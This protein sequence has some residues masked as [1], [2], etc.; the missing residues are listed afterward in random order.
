MH[1][2]L[3]FRIPALFCA[4][5]VIACELIAHPF[6]NM[7]VDDDGPYILMVQ[8]LVTTGHVAYNGWAAPMLTWQLYLAAAFVKLFGFSF[9]TVRGSTILV[10]A[11][12]AFFLQR[13]LVRS[14]INE[15][16][17]TI[18]TLA[19]V[20]SPLYLMLS[21]TFM[22]D[23]H[24]LFAVILCLYACLRALQSATPR[25]AIAWLCFAV[26]SNAVV[27]T[28][29]QI[30]WLGILVMVPS[31]LYL[32]RANRR[33]FL[34]GAA[35]TLA[36]V[37]FIFA[38]LHWLKHQP[39]NIP[40]H[41]LPKSLHLAHTLA[42]FIHTF[43]DIP[44]F[45]LPIFA[46]FLPQLRKSR[47]RV[48]AILSAIAI[49]YILLAIVRSH[50]HPNALLEPIEAD[51]VSPTGLFP[52]YLQGAPPVFLHPPVRLLLTIA[53][54]GGLIGLFASFTLPHK[55]PSPTPRLSSH[56]LNILLLPF[57]AANILLL[58]PRA[59]EWLTDRYLLILLA[60][61]LIFLTRFYQDQVRPR[62]P[63]TSAILVAIMATYAIAVTHNLFAL[64][65]ARVALAAE[66]RAAGIPD[67]A[68]DNGW[69]YN[70]GTELQFAPSLNFP[71]IV[72]PANFYTP[73]PPPP[74][75]TC[76]TYY[77]D[78]TPHVHPRIGVSFD[79]NACA[80]P[81]PFAPVHYS[82]WLASAPG[83]IYVVR[84]TEPA[85]P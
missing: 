43:L 49:G 4:L 28:S 11:V 7:G 10:A 57:A 9:T 53:S 60:I 35:A 41:I 44:F 25:A 42:E 16:N 40:E 30:A 38:C 72:V 15:R 37:V 31:T 33:V 21:V 14:N 78:E 71:T 36:G 64:D 73:T 47:P 84:Y 13:I 19:L 22:T 2:I 67:T 29:R 3:K 32:L 34:A 63:L 45:L 50:V 83:T 55:T 46:I 56:Q 23:I 6:V 82:R 65:R 75:G 79:P 26:A 27:G 85:K 24:G 76:T 17:A 5:A 80:G 81:A 62:L 77:A 66:T 69:E 51:Y 20:L 18:A 59:T 68:F 8:H 12:L 1:R 61:A 48:L 54:I 39:Y 74:P 70:F 58:I 52:L